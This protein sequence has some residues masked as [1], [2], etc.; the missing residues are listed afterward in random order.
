MDVIAFF[1]SDNEI[2]VSH[3][4]FERRSGAY[5]TLAVANTTIAK[6]TLTKTERCNTYDLASP[7]IS[8]VEENVAGRKTVDDGTQRDLPVCHPDHPPSHLQDLAGSLSQLT[9]QVS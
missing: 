7:K 4:F 5:T 9:L 3:L 1:F 2:D 6:A 8:V